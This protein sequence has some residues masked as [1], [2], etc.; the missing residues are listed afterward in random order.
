MKETIITQVSLIGTLVLCVIGIF[1]CAYR[2][3]N[4][5][6]HVGMFGLI[7][8]I[9]AKLWG[10]P[11]YVQVAHVGLFLYAIGTAWRV[12][13]F[14][15]RKKNGNYPPAELPRDKFRHVAGGSSLP[16]KELQ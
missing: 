15:P 8:G 13:K 10:D 16:T 4:F 5:M 14:R 1:H 11:D 12:Y 7:G 6:Q 3:H 9:G 2:Q